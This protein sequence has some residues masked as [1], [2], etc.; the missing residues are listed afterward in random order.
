MI[1]IDDSSSAMSGEKRQGKTT[2]VMPAQLTL[3][4]ITTAVQCFCL[5]LHLFVETVA[6]VKLRRKKRSAKIFVYILRRTTDSYC[7][8]TVGLDT[9]HNVIYH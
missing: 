9:I 2:S 5:F 6:F 7:R 3:D 1:V 4:R 8:P